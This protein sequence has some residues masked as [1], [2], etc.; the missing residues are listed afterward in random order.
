MSVSSFFSPRQ[1]ERPGVSLKMGLQRVASAVKTS[2][3][4]SVRS[5]RPA[6]TAVS[7]ATV[8]AR[9]ATTS[10]FARSAGRTRFSTEPA[11]SSIVR[12]CCPPTSIRRHSTRFQ[13]ARATPSLGAS[14][15]GTAVR[16]ASAVVVPLFFRIFIVRSPSTK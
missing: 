8:N 4:N 7:M 2:L 15:G 1:S 12:G 10:T 11:T 5:S 13:T 16:N 6:R 3:T 14:A 9:M